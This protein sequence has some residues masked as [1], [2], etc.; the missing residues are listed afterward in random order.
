[1]FSSRLYMLDP[2]AA[3]ME[4]WTD[5]GRSLLFSNDDDFSFEV[6]GHKLEGTILDAFVC[7]IVLHPSKSRNL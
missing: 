3:D 7:A 6:L 5:M 2:P 1:M 4:C